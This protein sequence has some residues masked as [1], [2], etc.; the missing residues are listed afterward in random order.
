M[1][2]VEK[3]TTDERW[4]LWEN[5]GDNFLQQ[6]AADYKEQNFPPTE[7]EAAEFLTFL[8]VFSMGC[9]EMELEDLRILYDRRASLYFAVLS[10]CGFRYKRQVCY[11]TKEGR[12]GGLTKVL[13]RACYNAG[14]QTSE[15]SRCRKLEETPTGNKKK[16]V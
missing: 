12:Y 14:K 4:K 5:S 2:E 3:T 10:K 11:W 9:R 16:G 7:L 6:L 1:T 13:S 15:I 8:I